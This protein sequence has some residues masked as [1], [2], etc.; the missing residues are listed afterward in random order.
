MNQFSATHQGLDYGAGTGP[1]VSV[2]LQEKG[3]Q[4]AQYDPFFYNNQGLLTNKYDYIVACEVIEHF[5]H[6]YKEFKLLKSLLE[7]TGELFCVTNLY[8]PGIDFGSWY[9]K[10]DITHVFIYQKDTLDWIKDNIGFS[11]VKINNR[12]IIFDGH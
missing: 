9:Y 10:N 1:V 2:M 12:L 3:Y 11:Q 5:H 6:P 8:N 4:I 7:E